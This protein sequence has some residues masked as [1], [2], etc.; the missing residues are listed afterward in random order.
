MQ[1]EN[2]KLE[3]IEEIC[4]LTAQNKHSSTYSSH[5]CEKK[6]ILPSVAHRR[7]LSWYVLSNGPPARAARRRSNV[8]RTQLSTQGIHAAICICIARH[9]GV[10]WTSSG[11]WHLV[12]NRGTWVVVI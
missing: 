2:E 11:D 3:R 5:E 7:W 12:W 4:L 10:A 6:I 9:D 8:N 1:S